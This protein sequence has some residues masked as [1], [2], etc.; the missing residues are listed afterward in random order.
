MEEK[1]G[2]KTRVSFREEKREKTR[3]TVNVFLRNA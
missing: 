3:V 2:E 1:R